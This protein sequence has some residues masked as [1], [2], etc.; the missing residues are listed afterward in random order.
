M[1][2]LHIAVREVK[3]GFRN[4]WAYSFM[5]LF[6]VFSLSL[7]LINTQ[8]FIEGYSSGTSTMLN[9]ILYLL[10]LM[11]L[12]IGSFSLTSEKEEGSWTLLSTYP[13]STFSFIVGKYTG[14]AV[15]LLIII[16]F[17]YGV[18]GIAGSLFG[19]G[20][21][22]QT[23]RLFIAFSAGLII[24]FLAVALC[25]GTWVRNRWQALTIGVAI[26]FFAVIG[27]PT[28]L[29]AVLGLLPYMW[30]KPL[31]TALTVLNPAELVRLFVVVKLGGGSAL[32]PE[33]YEW[34]RWIQAPSG[35]VSFLAIC[36]IWV[37]AAIGL[38]HWVWERGR[39]RG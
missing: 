18:T 38:A 4:P 29:V 39:V 9:F 7:L 20:L 16:A 10:P 14:V 27:W 13:I 12:L 35:T 1:N 36:L 8:S 30:I 15:V 24:L 22:F 31:L 17:G 23:Y 32:G 21:D 3:L 5:I 28:L 33:Y 19:R 2:L 37:S 25:V 6:T 34:V 11:T 26:W